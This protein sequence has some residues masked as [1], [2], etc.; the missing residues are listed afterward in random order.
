MVSI[1]RSLVRSAICLGALIASPDLVRARQWQSIGPDGGRVFALAID[2]ADEQTVYAG[3]RGALVFRSEDAGATWTPARSGL[4]G[5]DVSALAFDSVHVGTVYAGGLARFGGESVY[6][7]TDRGESWQAAGAGVAGAVTAL[8]TDPSSG[9]LFAGTDVSVDPRNGVFRSVDGAASWSQV[10]VA[11]QPD[12][13]VFPEQIF[14]VAVVPGAP[15]TVL[16]CTSFPGLLRSTDGGDTWTRLSAAF[17]GGPAGCNLLSVGA[18]PQGALHAAVGQ[19]GLGA[20]VYVSLDGGATWTS[21]GDPVPGI[22]ESLASHPSIPLRLYA[23]TL[24]QGLFISLDGGATW[25][26]TAPEV[27]GGVEAM[28]FSPSDG[29][30][31]LLGTP[32][33]VYLSTDAAASATPSRAG[34]SGSQVRAVAIAPTSPHTLYAAADESLMKST[35]AGE[36]WAPVGPANVTVRDIVIDPVDPNTVYAGRFAFGILKTVDGWDTWTTLPGLPPGGAANDLAIDPHDPASVYALV[37]GAPFF[38]ALGVYHSTDGGAS[39]TELAEGFPRLRA[40]IAIAPSEPGTVYLAGAVGSQGAVAK[41]TAADP[42]WRMLRSDLDDQVYSIAVDPT[43]ADRVW[44]GADGVHRSD[45]GGVTWTRVS[46]GLPPGREVPALSVD[47]FAPDHVFAFTT[48]GVYETVDGGASWAE[49]GI[50][51]TP[52]GIES[53]AAN[54]ALWP[55]PLATLYTGTQGG[56]VARLDLCN[57]TPSESLRLTLRRLGGDGVADHLV[58]RGEIAV[59]P[60]MD[61]DPAQHGVR[62]AVHTANGILVDATTLSSALWRK[63]GNSWRYA[64]ASDTRTPSIQSLRLRRSPAHPQTLAVR[65]VVTGHAVG[66]DA[67]AL[68]LRARLGV[69]AE[70]GSSVCGVTTFGADDCTFVKRDRR[71]ICR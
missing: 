24:F 9:A 20:Q 10:Y 54:L 53:I 7:S 8:V 18:N 22:I 70:D 33:G 44:A 43:D 61:V 17:S 56:G 1:G 42:R 30:R 40:A 58:L 23:G 14:D 27:P 31:V 32:R 6:K 13:E 59:E 46:N 47:P 69:V 67:D 38:A 55:G 51:L 28:A 15:S 57:D 12:P 21:T 65:A 3:L 48:R 25:T 37:D 63:S 11:E 66:L 19:S 16:A 35:D 36:H 34:L 4:P 64:D 71:L 60:A 68:P 45:D 62:I 50:G 26:A 52:P 5:G 29:D 41:W 49:A 39:W 2:P